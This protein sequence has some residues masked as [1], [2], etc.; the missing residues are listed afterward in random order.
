[1]RAALYVRVSDPNDPNAVTLD[2]QEAGCRGWCAEHGADVA[3]VYRES[4]TG[5]DFW[6]R[7]ELQRL[8]ADCQRGAYDMVVF[9]ATDRLSRDPE[10]Q[11]ALKVMV[12]FGGAQLACVTEPIPEDDTGSLVQFVRGWASKREWGQIRE[13]TMRGKRARVERGMVPGAGPDLYGY[14]KDRDAG[15][16]LV[17]EPEAAVVRRIFTL[18]SE[19]LPIREIAR[20]LNDE[21]IPSP[22]AGKFTRDLAAAKWGTGQLRRILRN[23]AYAGEAYAWTHQYDPVKRTTVTRD[24][25]E[26]IALPA[27]TVPAIVTPALWHDVQR[28]LDTNRGEWARSQEGWRQYLLR[29]HISCG[30]CGRRMYTD[31]QGGHRYYRCSSRRVGTP[32]GVGWVRA[33]AMEAEVWQRV[34]RFLLNPDVVQEAL[35]ARRETHDVGQLEAQIA[36]VNQRIDRIV[37]GQERLL[38]R[39]R[40]SDSVPWK[41]VEREIARAERERKAEERELAELKRQLTAHQL[42]GERM[43]QLVDWCGRVSANLGRFTFEDKRRTLDVLEVRVIADGQE[44]AI[45]PHWL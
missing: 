37:R 11:M 28:R 1:M 26:W 3:A 23:P 15:V 44:W 21:G 25:S 14:R 20:R 19:G 4:R 5:I 34:E 41:L 45:E 31:Y 33:D 35:A 36:A 18:A 16:R 39:Y 22:G 32:C 10:H 8:I 17:H 42:D 2:T 24:R 30:V 29:G 6:Q 9:Y 12:A 13:R 27:G 38:A 43:Q 7:P 40:E